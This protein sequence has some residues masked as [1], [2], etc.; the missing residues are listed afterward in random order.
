MKPLPDAQPFLQQVYQWAR[1]QGDIQALAVVGS[2]ARRTARPDSDIDLIIL[3]DCPGRYLEG[4]GWASQFGR[5]E[6]QQVED[7]GK[8]T[9]LRV[10][11]QAG[12]E[13]EYGLAAPDW[14]ALPVD[15]G[16]QRVLMDGI[17]LLYERTPCLSPALE[18]F[19]EAEQLYVA[20]TTA[21]RQQANPAIAEKDR[22]YAKNADFRSLGLAT[23]DRKGLYRLFRPLIR[24]LCLNGRLYLA[25]QLVF[26][27]YMEDGGFANAAL[28]LSVKELGPT[29]LSYLDEHLDH[30]HGWGQTDDFC[31]HV[32]QPLLWK[33]P[34]EILALLKSWNQS[35][36]LWKRRASVVA[37]TRKVGFSG[38]FTAQA[39]ELCDHLVWDKEDLV[40]K[41]VGWALKDGMRGDRARVLDY[42]KELRRRGVS[43]VITLYA[44]RD[45]EQVERQ[46]VLA[47]RPG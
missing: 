43:A 24:R 41:G 38:K 30:F 31:G 3:A 27:G 14:A 18:G 22:Y 15:P 39:L 26:T 25:R 33:H 47:I 42:L 21:I 10:G 5:P 17:Q 45:L 35:T 6:W 7:Y 23:A 36:N 20:I 32:L 4:Q 28:A 9:S 8:L 2:Q 40:R 34:Q 29:H 37:F 12:P 11:Y 19:A 1:Q 44:I 16:T 13:V 46:N